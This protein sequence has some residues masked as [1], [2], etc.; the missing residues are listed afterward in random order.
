MSLAT[1]PSPLYSQFH[2]K[3]IGFKNSYGDQKMILCVKNKDF[4]KNPAFKQ[5]KRYRRKT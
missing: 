1:P 3:E 5:P 4:R 2:K